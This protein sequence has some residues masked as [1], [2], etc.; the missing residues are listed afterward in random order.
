[1]SLNQKKR[2]I[3]SM[4]NVGAD[5]MEAIRKK[6]PDGWTNHV[7]RVDKGNGEFM[8]II[9]VDTEDISYLIKVKVKVDSHEE[10]EKFTKQMDAGLEINAPAEDNIDDIADSADDSADDTDSADNQSVDDN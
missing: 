4:E 2:I 1:M 5:V 6:Y 7:Q 10:V 8:H 3:K 9:T